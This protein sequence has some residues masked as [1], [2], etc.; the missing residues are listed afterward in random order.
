MIDHEYITFP[1]G[2]VRTVHYRRRLPQRV[3]ESSPVP[4]VP[5][6]AQGHESSS[7]LF[8]Y[9]YI[10]LTA[11]PHFHVADHLASTPPPQ[12][13]TQ[14]QAQLPAPRNSTIKLPPDWPPHHRHLLALHL[15]INSLLSLSAASAPSPLLPQ[16][17]RLLG[18]S[19]NIPLSPTATL[20][21]LTIY[22]LALGLSPLLLAPLSEHPRIGRRPVLLGSVLLFSVANTLTPIY[23]PSGKPSL[24]LIL[25]MRFLAGFGGG[26]SIVLAPAV[27]RDLYP[28]IEH[29]GKGLAMVGGAIYLGPAV[30]PILG[31]LVGAEG[32]L[33]WRW[34]FWIMAIWGAALFVLG[35][36]VVRES[37]PGRL[38][39]L[40]EEQG[41]GSTHGRDD[42][43]SS[44]T[45]MLPAAADIAG[46]PHQQ[47]PVARR[48]A[49]MSLRRSLLRPMRLMASRPVLLVYA[50][51]NAM[52]FGI[53]CIVLTTFATLWI[54]RYQQSETIASLHY[55]SIAL[56]ASIACQGTGRLMD[57]IQRKMASRPRIPVSGAE[58]KQ[59]KQAPEYRMITLALAAVSLTI[60]LICYGWTAQ[61]HAHWVVV[62]IGVAVWCFGVFGC[63]QTWLAY[64]SDEF[65]QYTG[66]ANAAAKLGGYMTG[67]LFPLFAP[68]LYA[69]W[70]Y[71][72]GNTVLAVVWAVVA[73]P[74]P[75]LLWKYGARL[76]AVRI[77]IRRETGY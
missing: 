54:E 49:A 53:Y 44:M 23:T 40:R 37:C 33:G 22:I 69:G 71:G 21:T 59:D 75:W 46:A 16:L 56:G 32:R 72:V 27:M 41:M 35:W 26:T 11:L 39:M 13:Q 18:P 51:L 19:S 28:K 74:V 34:V 66:S 7:S 61:K 42:S 64:I 47:I 76:R 25:L 24:A 2:R 31:G 60:G 15:S 14:T 55:I 65:G 48:A 38:E 77:T 29:R 45:A 12:T 68:K 52:S 70:G 50:L 10:E 36:C 67:F 1:D 6:A 17:S 58:V 73:L 57:V 62:D 8:G 20:L 43:I 9:E 3:P 5:Q 4:R 63:Q 30:G